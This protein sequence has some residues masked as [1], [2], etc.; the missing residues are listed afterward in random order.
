MQNDEHIQKILIEIAKT[1]KSEEVRQMAIKHLD[2]IDALIEIAQTDPDSEIRLE[3]ISRIGDN[4]EWCQKCQDILIQIAKTDKEYYIRSRVAE[5]IEDRK[6]LIDIAQNDESDFV[7]KEI[8]RQLFRP[9][10]NKLI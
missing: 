2:D 5:Y 4:A 1:D 9:N 3:A 6:I 7:R 8:I 10:I